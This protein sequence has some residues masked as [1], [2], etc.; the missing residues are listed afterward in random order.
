MKKVEKCCVGGCEHNKQAS[1][2]VH[3][4]HCAGTMIRI[5]IHIMGFKM[6]WFNIFPDKMLVLNTF[7]LLH[8]FAFPSFS[9]R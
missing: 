1:G 7:S 6:C 8:L 9:K 3:S 2:S 5:S 4:M